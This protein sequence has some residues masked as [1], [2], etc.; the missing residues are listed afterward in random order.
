MADPQAILKTNKGDITINLFP[1]H[2]P[3]TVASFVGLA[4]GNPVEVSP[5]GPYRPSPRRA[6]PARRRS[7]TASASTAS[8]P[9]S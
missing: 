3:R 8:S 9:A 6:R 4:T 7:T 5:D 1:N 2:A